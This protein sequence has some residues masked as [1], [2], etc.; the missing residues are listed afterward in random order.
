MSIKEDKIISPI[1]K[2]I[3]HGEFQ[4][5]IDTILNLEKQKTLRKETLLWLRIY[6]TRLLISHTW[7]ESLEIID[8]IIDEIKTIENPVLLIEAYLSKIIIFITI[9]KQN[10]ALPLLDDMEKLIEEKFTKESIELQNY[11]A[12]I[13]FQKG[14]CFN[15]TGELDKA[16]KLLKKS[17][18]L[19]KKLKD[20]DLLYNIYDQLGTNSFFRANYD[21][22]IK[23]FKKLLKIGKEA[24]N[25]YQIFG[26]Y[27]SLAQAYQRIGKFEH[28]TKYIE[29]SMSVGKE[30]GQNLSGPKYILALNYYSMGE[31]KKAHELFREVLPFYEG[32]PNPRAKSL[33]LW[34]KSSIEWYSGSIEKTID[35]LTEAVEILKELNDKYLGTLLAIYLASAINDKGEYDK[36]LDLGIENFKIFKD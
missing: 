28:S 1:K 31:I 9:Q 36:A 32:I 16:S 23:Y 27:N 4:K 17:E 26:A 30:L 29:Q 22:A 24:N 3:S 13:F 20:N 7:S 8:E 18:T 19:S 21:E 5:A 11:L 25:N 35:Y 34:M 14:A 15:Y 10:E 33:A 6:K 2:M 12:Q